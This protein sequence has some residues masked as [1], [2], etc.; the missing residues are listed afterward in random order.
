[1][2]ARRA[3]DAAEALFF[4]RC[5]RL[6]VTDAQYALVCLS[7]RELE[8]LIE[9]LQPG[10]LGGLMGA[11]VLRVDLERIVYELAAIEEEGR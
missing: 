4:D 10:P 6:E 1:V 8:T 7:R 3:V 11:R 2:N 9:A 5:Q